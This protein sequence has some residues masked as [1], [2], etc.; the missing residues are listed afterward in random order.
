MEQAG[1]R[2]PVFHRE[3]ICFFNFLC[4]CYV[5]LF[6]CN[7]FAINPLHVLYGEWNEHI[8]FYKAGGGFK[9][10]VLPCDPIKYEEPNRV[11]AA[12]RPDSCK[13]G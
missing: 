11:I 8:L 6:S 5:A 3:I 13:H 9:G 4:L 1:K 10:N 12:Q 2:F 7:L